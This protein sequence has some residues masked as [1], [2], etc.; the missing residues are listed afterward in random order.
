MAVTRRRVLLSAAVVALAA[1]GGSG[2]EPDASATSTS[3]RPTT[4]VDDST[5]V[6]DTMAPVDTAIDP[7]ASTDVVDADTLGTA[8][9]SMAPNDGASQDVI[10]QAVE[11]IRQRIDALGVD[12]SVE[13]TTELI[14]VRLENVTAREA[15]SYV[16]ASGQVMVQPVMRMETADGAGEVGP[17]LVPAADGSAG[18]LLGDGL[19]VSTL[20][21][22][23]AMVQLLDEEWTVAVTLTTGGQANW[24]V[25]AG[26]CYNRDATCP[27]GQIAIV[28]DG[29]VL[30][31]PV[32]QTDEFGDSVSIAGNFTE[33]AATRLAKA[34]DSGALPIQLEVVSVDFRPN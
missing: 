7:T 3:Q 13:V 16:T 21:E 15:R 8:V 30:S 32:V 5:T 9:I 34:L 20:I 10:D 24:N 31:A 11:L 33:V 25:L 2:D 29:E 26:R 28:L 23:G 4:A 17:G 19:D 14:R 22:P 1:C 27:T 12:A 18:Y 6:A